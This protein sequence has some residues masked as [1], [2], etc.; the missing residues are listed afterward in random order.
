MR[1]LLGGFMALFV[2]AAQPGL[3]QQQQLDAGP[4]PRI[5]VAAW[6]PDADHHPGDSS[7]VR[8][9]TSALIE[10]LRLLG[11]VVLPGPE[12]LADS[13]AP[14]AP[15]DVA[16]MLR[17]TAALPSPGRPDALAALSVRG[18]VSITG[19]GAR[20]RAVVEI[21]LR[22]VETGEIL[23]RPMAASP[24]AGV[25]VEMPC[26]RACMQEA[27]G[28]EAADLATELAVEISDAMVV[29]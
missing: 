28:A 3:A 13:A 1:S 29:R 25:P 14:G 11:V 23:G 2:C 15:I 5:T 21:D 24:K 16:D 8:R 22:W 12:A 18:N 17:A 9:A 27:F 26:S 20:L 6:Q 7:V 10:R 19:D 4:A